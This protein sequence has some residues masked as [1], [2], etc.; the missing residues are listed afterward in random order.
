MTRPISEITAGLEPSRKGAPLRPGSRLHIIGVGGTAALAAALHAQA[1]GV[2]VSGYDQALSE[3]SARL[4]SDAAIPVGSAE[5]PEV[6]RFCE[7]LSPESTVAISKA[8]TSTQPQHPEVLLARKAGAQTISVQ[9][10]IADAAATRGG[11]LIGVGGTHG[12]TTSTGW[13]LDALNHSGIK[14]SAFVGGPLAGDLGTPAGSPVH[15]GSDAGFIVEADEYGGNFDAYHVDRALILNVDWDHPDI[16]ADRLAAVDT[17]ARWSAYPAA[18]GAAFINTG[19]QGGAELAARLVRDGCHNVYTF[20][21]LVG[22]GPTQADVS[23]QLISRGGGGYSIS[24]DRVSDR[25]ALVAPALGDLLNRELPIGLLGAHNASNGLGVAFLAASV[26]GTADGIASSLATFGGVGRRMEV[27]YDRNSITVLD[28]YGHHPT[29]IDAT[30][31][32]VR[33]RYP[34]RTLLL[35]IE[36]LTYHRTSALLEGLAKS[37]SRAD[38]VAVAEIFAVRDLDTTSVSAATLAERIVALGT[39]ATAPGTVLDTAAALLPAI[40]P[41][42]VVLVMGGGRS[43]ELA[44]ALAQGLSVAP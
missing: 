16:F 23:A 15:I 33:Q 32:T 18:N 10:V 11:L 25:A 42:T 5:S 24:V 2:R 43:T 30:I 35:A 38:R 29:A 44:R 6:L 26:K 20:T 34:G 40:E 17:F 41:H 39:P 13:V 12:K 7:R 3:D 28:D 1:L 21:L 9:Q 36:P 27:R 4:L 22:T 37:C 19:D 31:A 14:M 8:I